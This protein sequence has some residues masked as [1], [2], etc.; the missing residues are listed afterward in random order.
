MKCRVHIGQRKKLTSSQLQSGSMLAKL[1]LTVQP[2]ADQVEN[3]E[4]LETM[5][6]S[7]KQP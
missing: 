1:H 5:E 6:N 7:T 4:I 2:R 3:S